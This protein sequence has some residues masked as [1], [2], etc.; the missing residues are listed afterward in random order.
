MINKSL[1]SNPAI[2]LI[3]VVYIILSFMT[4]GFGNQVASWMFAEDHYFENVGALSFFVTSV[5]FFWA[6]LTARNPHNTPKVFWLKP[7]VYLALAFI[8]FFGAGEEISWGQRIFNLQTPDLLN[9]VNKQNEITIHNIS[10]AGHQIPFEFFFDVFWFSLVI[11]LPILSRYVKPIKQFFGR[12]MPI[13]SLGIGLLFLCNYIFAKVAKAI[14]VTVYT[15]DSV[16]FIQAV[17]E[18]KES[19]Y[20]LLWILI[21][22]FAVLELSHSAHENQDRSPATPL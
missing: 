20:A 5:L 16:P 8:F 17:Q 19:N 14:F 21:A 22:L 12:F 13:V 18:T 2:Y 9:A 6:F 4:L 7:L 3:V 10:I 11:L 1:F 15:F